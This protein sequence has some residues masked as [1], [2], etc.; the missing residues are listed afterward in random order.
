M[1]GVK[2]APVFR[3][4]EEEFEKPLEYIERIRNEAEAAGICKIVPPAGWKP[5]FA[6]DRKSFRFNTRVQD[7]CKIDGVARIEREFLLE[8]RKHLFRRGIGMEQLPVV[9]PCD[10]PKIAAESLRLY[11]LF[12]V[13][14]SFGGSSEVIVGSKW[15]D[16][17]KRMFKF[18]CSHAKHQELAKILEQCYKRYLMSYEF[19]GTERIQPW[20][21]K[22]CPDECA[23]F[24]NLVDR[25]S[26]GI[27]L[28]RESA[29]V[30]RFAQEASMT[31]IENGR[32]ACDFN[33]KPT[34]SHEETLTIHAA[35][36]TVKVQPPPAKKRKSGRAAV[37]KSAKVLQRECKTRRVT[38][39]RVHPRLGQPPV[40]K[41]CVGARFYRYYRDLQEYLVG[42]VVDGKLKPGNEEITW[43]VQYRFK[44][45][46]GGT[47]S[48]LEDVMDTDMV[49]LLASGETEEEAKEALLEGMCQICLRADRPDCML[50]CD[51]CNFGYHS[52][53]I[54]PPLRQIPK[55]DWFCSVCLEDDDDDDTVKKTDDEDE[56]MEDVDEY[57]A[58]HKKEE[59]QQRGRMRNMIAAYG[60]GQGQQYSI[61]E[62]RIMA[63]S[64]K[65][66]YLDRAKQGKNPHTQEYIERKGSPEGDA[67]LER[68]YWRLISEA[69]RG[70][71][72]LVKL[73]VSYGSDLDTASLGSGFPSER[74]INVVKARM[75]ILSE[76]MQRKFG[77]AMNA[78]TR[79]P[80]Y[81]ELKKV[82]EN[83]ESY[84]DDP[85]NLN[86]FPRLQGSLLQHV[87]EDI[88]GVIVPWL[89]IGMFFS[90]FCWH[91][92][93][94]YF[95]SINYHHWGEPK[96]WYGVPS[97]GAAA[98]EAAARERTPELFNARP[99]ILTGIVTQYNPTEMASAG[100]PVYHT[101][102]REGEF[103]LTFPQAYHGGFNHGL[104]CAEAV[105]FATP[106]WLRF[107]EDCVRRYQSLKKNPVIPHEALLCALANLHEKGFR[108]EFTARLLYPQFYSM[109]EKEKSLRSRCLEKIPNLSESI[110]EVEAENNTP[111]EEDA[112]DA[113][114]NGG[115]AYGRERTHH[116]SR[117]KCVDTGSGKTIQKQCTECRRF[118]SLSYIQYA[119][120]RGRKRYTC[121]V[122]ALDKP[123]NAP[124]LRIVVTLD[125]LAKLQGNLGNV[126]MG[127]A[128]W[129]LEVWKVFCPSSAPFFEIPPTSGDSVRQLSKMDEDSPAN[130]ELKLPPG[131]NRSI[132]LHFDNHEPRLTYG[133]VHGLF[134]AAKAEYGLDPL[135]QKGPFL[136]NDLLLKDVDAYLKE[137]RQACPVIRGTS[138]Q[139][140][141]NPRD[142]WISIQSC[143]A[144][145]DRRKTFKVEVTDE[146]IEFFVEWVERAKDWRVRVAKAI[147]LSQYG[148]FLS[149]GYGEL[150]AL[151]K[152]MDS[153]I[154]IRE[155]DMYDKLVSRIQACK[156]LEK[157]PR[158]LDDGE[159]LVNAEP[160]LEKAKEMTFVSSNELEI[161]NKFEQSVL[162][163]K[164]LAKKISAA[165]KE[166]PLNP[167]LLQELKHKANTCL[168]RPLNETDELE[169]ELI[170]MARW[171][172][173]AHE[174]LLDMADDHIERLEE[175]E[176]QALVEEGLKLGYTS[177]NSPQMAGL[178]E[179]MGD[180]LKFR[181]DGEALFLTV[182][183]I[184][185]QAKLPYVPKRSRLLASMLKT[186]YGIASDEMKKPI[187][188]KVVLRTMDSNPM[189]VPNKRVY[190]LCRQPEEEGVF[191]FACDGCDEWYHPECLGS[192]QE[193]VKKLE[194]FRCP[195][196][197]H[198]KKIVWLTDKMKVQKNMCFCRRSNS[199][200]SLVVECSKCQGWYHPI[201]CGI[202]EIDAQTKDEF[203]CPQ[204][205]VEE[206]KSPDVKLYC[207]CRRA[208]FGLS[209]K[210]A[211]MIGCDGCG[212]WYHSICVDINA[213][214][215]AKKQDSFFCSKCCAINDMPFFQSSGASGYIASY[216]NLKKTKSDEDKKCRI[217]FQ[218][219]DST[220]V[221]RPSRLITRE[222]VEVL[223]KRAEGLS[224]KLPEESLLAKLLELGSN[225]KERVLE[226]HVE[227]ATSNHLWQWLR[228]GLST[229]IEIPDN[230]FARVHYELWIR[231][232]VHLWDPI[233]A[234]GSRHIEKWN[235]DMILRVCEA[236]GVPSWVR[237]KDFQALQNTV[238]EVDGL[239]KILIAKSADLTNMNV[240][241]VIARA[242]IVD[243]DKH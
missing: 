182:Q 92:E 105:N 24:K 50:L 123:L 107:G 136:L 76:K 60:Y 56:D 172:D 215:L 218:A 3:P 134:T 148:G 228:Y 243:L 9:P 113:A 68:E 183:G 38:R 57:E 110:V 143:L 46:S 20:D 150:V 164:K 177:Q 207:G 219:S 179:A 191:M 214:T 73:N 204:C 83:Y 135:H 212:E 240:E 109:T 210:D 80:K 236:D 231:F 70:D 32:A 200:G 86:N 199:D 203:I 119:D 33:D 88:T 139:R 6:V 95:A 233:N 149:H 157:A 237:P 49:M 11:R 242:V 104:N 35:D 108:D 52:V 173:R 30:A 94:H 26:Y 87:E 147:T 227:N 15:V 1:E 72:E 63:D 7:L 39:Q 10:N 226:F 16:V 64:F 220:S 42:Q 128:K 145:L 198:D 117:M 152:E 146:L 229:F 153:E 137:L 162:A 37:A 132:R 53:C 209:R 122:H 176:L 41:V 216:A 25:M 130:Y 65:N 193:E 62:Y 213:K 141:K 160:F 78:I 175:P 202:S 14:K 66:E 36:D 12:D 90:S 156:W 5:P 239:K 187:T 232:A 185:P 84:C 211:E 77:P 196:C 71:M 118:C 154:Q 188:S 235:P 18:V 167:I 2:E 234:D 189:V 206:G 103:I 159:D 197:I 181:R 31:A 55:G 151:K 23:P 74:S 170:V 144:L 238:N 190:C 129:R 131:V 59:Q 91:T 29:A 161:V 79:S 133:Q 4:T 138:K 174:F 82:L 8:V 192:T 241:A 85:W 163:A 34:M 178:E 168:I 221:A 81:V 223:L 101:T 194:L 58:K 43:K 124:E 22:Q 208:D 48:H 114:A 171:V 28:G 47:V 142:K 112:Q 54:T 186:M 120:E 125:H 75:K 27:S 99:D 201:C 230:I 121:L 61:E 17:S 21:N 40:P 166:R 69:G 89:Y 140:M 115:R 127:V 93:D 169:E 116:M 100:V 195:T 217:K 19:A 106:K 180:V 44:N 205:C 51:E 126:A 224:V 165:L 222:K 67:A 184:D 102:Q 225:W 98:F 13:V 111:N 158:Y 45:S 155:A 97:T 96:T